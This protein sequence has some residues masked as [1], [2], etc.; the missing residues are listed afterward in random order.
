MRGRESVHGVPV[1][2]ND[3]TRAESVTLFVVDQAGGRR[4]DEVRP[5]RP[6]ESYQQESEDRHGVHGLTLWELKPL[7]NLAS[8]G[9]ESRSEESASLLNLP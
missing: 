2:A 9:F 3:N 7:D 4:P 5:I 8:A 6:R 1:L